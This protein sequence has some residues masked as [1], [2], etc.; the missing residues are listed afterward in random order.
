MGFFSRIGNKLSHAYSSASRLG[1]KVLG[2]ASRI[3]HK[4]LDVGNAVVNTVDSIPI[5]NKVLASPI[6]LAKTGLGVIQTGVDLADRGKE[7]LSGA[8]RVVK[9]GQDAL[10]G[11]QV[12]APKPKGA[13]E[14]GPPATAP[15]SAGIQAHPKVSPESFHR[16]G[17]SS[18][19]GRGGGRG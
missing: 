2:G 5:L 9:A 19:G 4:V 16:S 6:A 17:H 11:P 14:K 18:G 10:R 1:H 12:K 13:I 7:Y 15:P 3:G 8:D